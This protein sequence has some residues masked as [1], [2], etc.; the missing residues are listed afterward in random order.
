MAH[1]PKLTYTGIVS[2]WVVPQ[3]S[4]R[5]VGPQSNFQLHPGT[6]PVVTCAFQVQH[7]ISGEVAMFRL[8]N[9]FLP[10]IRRR[11]SAH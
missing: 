10:F 11:V 6:T 3:A 9:L 1:P 8:K 4:T 2:A 7:V 5:P